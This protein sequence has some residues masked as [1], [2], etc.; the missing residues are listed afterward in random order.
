MIARVRRVP[1]VRACV[2]LRAGPRRVLE[3]RCF[4]LPA[5]GGCAV[6]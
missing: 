6:L 5:D 3:R 4:A 1:Q 2:V